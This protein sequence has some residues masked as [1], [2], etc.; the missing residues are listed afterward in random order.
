MD[1]ASYFVA[2]DGVTRF[3]LAEA[4][5]KIQQGALGHEFFPVPPALRMQCDKAMKP[6][7]DYRDRMA[8]RRKLAEEHAAHSPIPTRTPAEIAS[9]QRMLADFHAGYEKEAS[10]FVPT[11]DPEMVAQV[12]DNPKARERMGMEAK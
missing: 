2:L 12:P 3:G 9:V 4:V 11:L 5:R 7:E 10:A 6:Y 1:R 8:H